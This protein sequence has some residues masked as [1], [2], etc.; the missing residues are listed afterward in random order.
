MKPL[1]V[2][3]W[4]MNPTNIQEAQELFK[5]VG[6]GVSEVDGAEVVICPPFIYLGQ[7][8]TKNYKLQTGAQNCF[9]ED[10]GTFT[11]EV[12]PRMLKNLGCSYVILGHSERKNYL[13]EDASEINRKVL[14]AVKANLIPIICIGETEKNSSENR[15][16]IEHQ[17]KSI[18]GDVR[19]AQTK[20]MVLTYEP[21]WAISSNED[22]QPATPQ[23]CQNAIRFMRDTL[24]DMFGM[25]VAD[26]MPILYGGSVDSKN[27][28]SFMKDGEAQGALV[29][30]A[31]LDA[32]EFVALVKNAAVG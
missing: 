28:A 12:S 20:G 16:Q 25:E 26:G 5:A 9:W 27:I 14:A 10:Q 31:S 6:K 7:L 23:D 15:Q 30:S 22:A 1:I 13:K 21:E 18:L 3:N 2:A 29:G 32:K 19:Y 11:G 17:V 8:K 4:K 24:A